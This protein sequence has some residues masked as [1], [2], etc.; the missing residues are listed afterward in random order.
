MTDV[1]AANRGAGGWVALALFWAGYVPLLVVVPRLFP[2]DPRFP[3]VA[4]RLGYSPRVAFLA[5]AIWSAVG[6]VG[7]LVAVMRGWLRPPAPVEG[8][9]TP[10]RSGLPIAAELALAVLAP[11]AV[12]F[13]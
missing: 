5:A 3:S 9:A 13:P 4:A 7:F 8:A 1:P 10:P 12:Y 6:L 11:L 2:V